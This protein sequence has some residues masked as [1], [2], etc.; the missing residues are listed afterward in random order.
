MYR[1]S[2]AVGDFFVQNRKLFE[3]LTIALDQTSN[4]I[5]RTILYLFWSIFCQHTTS[6]T[7]T[8]VLQGQRQRQ[9][10][11][12]QQQQQQ[13][14]QRQQQRQQCV[15]QSIIMII[16]SILKLQH[17]YVFIFNIQYFASIMKF[18]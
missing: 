17:T 6:I 18:I 4:D 11:R 15:N 7:T 14:Q 13:Q 12:Q 3:V 10:Q 2:E 16:G 1:N 8:T 9:R 5:V